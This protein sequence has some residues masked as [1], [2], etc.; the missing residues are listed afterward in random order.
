MSSRGKFTFS[1]SKKGFFAKKERYELDVIFPVL[2]GLNGED[3]TIQ[4]L[5]ELLEVPYASPS[6]L[7]SA[8]WMNKTL[9]K[10]VF[11]SYWFPQTKHL[12]YNKSNINKEEILKTL[13]TP[14]FVK[15]ANL[16]SS[17]WVSK[18]S[19]EKI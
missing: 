17:I 6:L 13:Q 14:I 18:V 8:I 1:Q 7:W 9:M 5:C 12:V 19:N 15:P 16:G 2:H 10:Q 11:A 3:W 4:G